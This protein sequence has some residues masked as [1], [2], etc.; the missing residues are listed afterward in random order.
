MAEE[1]IKENERKELIRSALKARERAY[2]PYSAFSV[3]AAILTASGEIFS[4][5]NVENASYGAC[6]CA[7]RTA[8][9]KAVSSG[10]KDF[11]AIAVAGGPAG[12]PAKYTYPCG[13]CRQFLREFSGDELLI[14]IVK[15]EASV[16]CTSLAALL[17]E[18][19]GP[20]DLEDPAD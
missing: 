20:D 18:S 11:R 14:L 5:C 9:V 7:E 13:I 19:F 1:K 12:K 10:Q 17:P 15:D 4:G 3:G 2:A 16:R 6:I 8:A